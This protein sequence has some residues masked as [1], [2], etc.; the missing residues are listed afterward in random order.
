MSRRRRRW[1]FGDKKI[2]S[3]KDHI[4]KIKMICQPEGGYNPLTIRVI[5]Y[6]FYSSEVR[7]TRIK[8]IKNPNFRKLKGRWY[9]SPIYI[10][11]FT[12]L[13]SDYEIERI[14]SKENIISLTLLK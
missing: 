5:Q 6:P 11:T 10:V 7:N 8:R 4:Y 3:P 14:K 1:L 13:I 2:N 12:A 9:N